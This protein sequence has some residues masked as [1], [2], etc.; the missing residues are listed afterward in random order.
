MESPS[1]TSYL[2]SSVRRKQFETRLLMERNGQMS[3]LEQRLPTSST[4]QKAS[5]SSLRNMLGSSRSETCAG[6]RAERNHS[7][8][9]RPA[10]FSK[11]WE[12]LPKRLGD[13]NDKL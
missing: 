2:R 10:G 1:T 12:F 8:K 7:L 6:S 9:R 3:R 5:M 4:S 13:S 11:A